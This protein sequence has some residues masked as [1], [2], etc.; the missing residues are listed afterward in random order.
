MEDISLKVF[1]TVDF[2]GVLNVLSPADDLVKEFWKQC[3]D[4]GYI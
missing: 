1:G 4:G 2:V 3:K